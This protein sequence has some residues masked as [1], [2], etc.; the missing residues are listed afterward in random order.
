MKIIKSHFTFNR[1]QRSGI[2]FLVVLITGLLGVYYGVDF[3]ETPQL[4]ISSAEIISLQKEIDSLQQKELE[5][6]KPKHYPFN[7]NFITDFK[8]YTL[9]ITPEEF[10]RLKAYREKGQWINSSA[11]FQ[12]VTGISDS[13][14]KN[15]SPFFKFPEWATNPKPEKKEYQNSFTERPFSQKADL[16][17]VTA[18]QLQEVSGI[19]EALS[20]RIVAY[21]EKLGSFS[22]DL[23]LYEVYGLDAGVV[24]RALNQFTVKT[25]KEIRKMDL[26]TA[27]ASDIATIPGIS[28][29]LARRI[30]EFR[31]LHERI[32]DFSEIE[33]I[34][35]LTAQKLQLIQLYLSVE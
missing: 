28:F 19:G 22:N 20:K 7:P 26:N 10:D 21:R 16:N 34:E 15:T 1:Q 30:W 29:E 35:G 17:S 8:A 5:N 4:D 3:S 25:P 18:T 12:K 14:L 31:V 33:K 6:R 13:I 27:T 23:Q 2:L 32:S 24:R 11:D 9:G